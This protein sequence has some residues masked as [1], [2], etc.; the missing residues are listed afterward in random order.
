M[1]GLVPLNFFLIYERDS[2][3]PICNLRRKVIIYPEPENIEDPS[4]FLCIDLGKP[5]LLKKVQVPVYPELGDCL[6]IKGVRQQEWYGRVRFMNLANR[7]VTVQWYRETNRAG[8]WTL[9]KDEDE[10]NLQSI[11]C[12]AEA[13][14]T[15]G[16]FTLMDI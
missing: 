9:T 11:I 5:E 15:F 6:K 16:G 8:I 14:R 2:V 4:Y 3:Q 13:Q 7:K 10:I 12:L 1:N